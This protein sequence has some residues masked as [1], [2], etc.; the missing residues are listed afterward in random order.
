MISLKRQ[1][2]TKTT[3]W[4]YYPKGS[5]KTGVCDDAWREWTRLEALQA[6]AAWERLWCLYK[7]LAKYQL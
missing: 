2:R 4:R 1:S 5:I 3:K 6:S 7:V